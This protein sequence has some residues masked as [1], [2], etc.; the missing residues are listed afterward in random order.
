[1]PARK[2]VCVVGSANMDLVVSCDRFP[3]PGE[4][5]LAGEFATY[6]GG[7]GANQAVAAARLGWPVRFIGKTGND[8]FREGLVASL[9]AAGI[10]TGSLLAD[11]S[12]STGVALITVDGTGQNTILVASGSNMRLAPDDLDARLFEGAGVVLLQLEIP[13]DTVRRAAELGRA[14]GAVVILN[15]APAQAVPDDL[16]RL[17]DIIT[18]NESEA[19]ALAGPDPG[20]DA[21]PVVAARRLVER[22]VACVIVTIGGDGALLVDAHGVRRFSAVP[23]E[24][25]DTTAAGDAFNGGLAVRLAAGDS[26]DAGIEYASRVAACCVARNG[27]Q[28]AMPTADEVS[29]L[30]ALSEKSTVS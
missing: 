15:P 21:D 1:M 18:P 19:A 9:E 7:K 14:A 17:V 28:N 20:G 26:V 29:A 8:T 24:V 10:D 27:A 2:H 23:V 16:L 30:A 11:P 12:A 6:A 3:L 4:T 5:L 25:V 22:G 13:I